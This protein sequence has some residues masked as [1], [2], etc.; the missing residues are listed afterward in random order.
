M[1]RFSLQSSLKNSLAAMFT[2]KVISFKTSSETMNSIT[3]LIL[4]TVLVILPI[5][6]AILLHR[7]RENLDKDSLKNKIGSLYLGMK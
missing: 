4:L 6:Y 3:G 5:F 7:N 1:L 2:I